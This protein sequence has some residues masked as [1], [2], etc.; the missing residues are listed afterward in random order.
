MFH[1]LEFDYLLV[2]TL[3]ILCQVGG[4]ALEFGSRGSELRVCLGEVLEVWGLC[5]PDIFGI[6]CGL[7]C[8]EWATRDSE[9]F[10]IE[11]RRHGFYDFGLVVL[12]R[13]V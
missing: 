2:G 3:W 12:V 11:F 5:V 1:G 9:V 6:S 4:R 7:D 10:W 8:R 13:W